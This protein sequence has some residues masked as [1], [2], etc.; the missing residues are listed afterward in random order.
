VNPG[1]HGAHVLVTRPAH[2]A[3]KLC[4][5]IQEQG[6]TAVRFPTLEIVGLINSSVNASDK[7]SSATY[8]IQPLSEYQWLIF[9]STNA[10]NFALKANGGKIGG[11]KSTSIASIGKA[12]AKTLQTAGIEVNLLPTAGFD[13]E[14]LLAMPE[15]QAV[16]DANI[17]IVKGQGGREELANVLRQRGAYVSYWEVYKRVRPDVDCSELMKLIDHDKLDVIIITSSESL[18]N[19]V[20]MLGNKYNKKL[21]TTALVVVSQRIERFA[22]DIGFTRISVAECPSDEAILETAIAVYNG[23]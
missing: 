15:M 3:E 5:L 22:A 4:Q 7:I 1:L 12:T 14:A 20:D 9:T 8:P 16:G 18:Q 17:L 6:G 10:V 23:D 19:L 2:Q 11:F 13:S 21:V